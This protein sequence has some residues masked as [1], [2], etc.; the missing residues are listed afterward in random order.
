MAS[1]VLKLIES[2]GFD[3][4]SFVDIGPV[5]KTSHEHASEVLAGLFKVVLLV[6]GLIT[7]CSWFVIAELVP[8]GFAALTLW[9]LALHPIVAWGVVSVFLMPLY[10]AVVA[11]VFY[12]ANVDT[13]KAKEIFQQMVPGS[14]NLFWS[15]EVHDGELHF[16][17][18]FWGEFWAFATNPVIAF[19]LSFTS[20]WRRS[21]V[22]RGV[23]TPDLWL[24][25][26][27]IT[28]VVPQPV[29]KD[30]VLSVEAMIDHIEKLPGHHF[31]LWNDA[32]VER[33]PWAI[34]APVIATRLCVLSSWTTLGF[35]LTLPFMGVLTIALVVLV[36]AKKT[37][38]LLVHLVDLVFLWLG[39]SVVVFLL[40]GDAAVK[41][42]CLVLKASFFI[43]SLC[44]RLANPLQ[45][46][47]LFRLLRQSIPQVAVV[48][49]LSMFDW[50]SLQWGRNSSRR[51][52]F[53]T[54][55]RMAK[56][57]EAWIA[58]QR[59]VASMSLP[60]FTTNFP[61]TFSASNLKQTFEQLSVLGW[62]VNVVV[63]SY[64]KAEWA[65]WSDWQV[66]S[67]DF[68]QGIHRAQTYIDEQLRVFEQNNAFIYKRSESYASYANELAATSRYFKDV[69]YKFS[70]LQSDELWVLVGE[71]FRDSQLTSFSY[72]I[73]RW[74]KKYGLGAFAKVP[75][76][77]AERK[78]SRRKFI[79]E[80]G[81]NAFSELWAKTFYHAPGMVPVAP[82]SIKGEALP[83]KKWF[84]DKVRTVIGAPLTH[85]ITSTIFNYGPNHNFKYHE[86]PIKVGL[87]LTGAG[88]TTIWSRHAVK[89]IHYAGDCS[90]FDSTLSGKIIDLIKDVRKK[91][92]EKHR[93]Y[94]RICQLID[95]EYINIASQ[96]LAT[97]SNGRVFRKG[98]GLTTGHSS[99]SMDNSLGMVALYLMAW[100]EITGMSSQSFRHYVELSVYGDD[101]LIS[102]SKDAP[103]A[104][105][106]PNIQKVMAGWGITNRLEAEGDLS[107]LEFLSKFGRRPSSADRTELLAAGLNVPDWVI[108]HNRDK[109]IGKI[110][111][112]VLSKDLQY[113]ASRIKS[114][115]SLTAHHRD[116]YEQ[117]VVALKTKIEI[118][119][120]KQPTYKMAIPSYDS[121]LK[122]WYNSSAKV[123]KGFD[124]EDLSL[125]EDEDNQILVYGEI[126]LID[127]IFNVFGRIVD[128]LNPDVFNSSLTVFLQ[129]PLLPF[130]TWAIRFT[131]ESNFAHGDR[132]VWQLMQKSSY[133][134]IGQEAE[135]PHG[136]HPGTHTSR[137]IKHWLYM[138]F[139]NPTGGIVAAMKLAWVDHKLANIK[140]FLTG[141]IDLAIK[142]VDVPLWNMLLAAFIGSLPDFEL[143]DVRDFWIV[144]MFNS[145]TFGGLIDTLFGIGMNLLW[146]NI[147]PSFVN[148]INLVKQTA[149]GKRVLIVAPTGTGKSTTMVKMIAD[150]AYFANKVVV[151]VPR[152]SLAKGIPGYM[153]RQYNLDVG[154]VTS[155]VNDFDHKVVYVTPMEVLLHPWW[156]NDGGILWLLDEAHI[157]ESLSVF[158]RE[159]VLAKCRHVV[160]TTA[161][162]ITEDGLLVGRLRNAQIWS[163]DTYNDTQI[164]T[165]AGGA[166][167][168]VETLKK[169]VNKGGS[170]VVQRYHASFNVYVS[171]LQTYL[172]NANPFAKSL[173]FVNTRSES[174]IL[175]E[176]LR[177]NA[178]GGVALLYSG[179]TDIPSTASI[180]I[181]TSVSDVGVTIPA[182]DHVFTMNVGFEVRPSRLDY[183]AKPTYALLSKEVLMQRRGRTG[184][185]NNGKFIVFEVD[186]MPDAQPIEPFEHVVNLL[187]SGV[188]MATIVDLKPDW[189][190]SYVKNGMDFEHLQEFVVKW[191]AAHAAQFKYALEFSTDA[192]PSDKI[193]SHLQIEIDGYTADFE[194]PDTLTPMINGLNVGHRWSTLASFTANLAASL[195]F[196]GDRIYLADRDSMGEA[197][198][199]PT[200]LASLWER[201]FQSIRQAMA[202]DA[203][204]V[205]E[206]QAEQ[207]LES[208]VNAEKKLEKLKREKALVLIELARVK[209]RASIL[210]PVVSPKAVVDSLAVN[211]KLKDFTL[212]ALEHEEDRFKGLID[213][214]VIDE[215]KVSAFAALID[216]WAEM[217]EDKEAGSSDYE[218]SEEYESSSDGAESHFETAPAETVF[219]TAESPVHSDEEDLVKPPTPVPKSG[220]QE[221]VMTTDQ[222]HPDTIPFPDYEAISDVS[223]EDFFCPVNLNQT[224]D[225]PYPVDGTIEEKEI[226]VQTLGRLYER[227]HTSGEGLLCGARAISQAVKNA[228]DVDLVLDEVVADL[229][230]LS[231]SENFFNVQ[232]LIDY[233]AMYNTE[234]AVIIDGR[235]PIIWP[236]ERDADGEFK[237]RLLLHATGFHYENYIL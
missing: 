7:I 34:K 217:Q 141:H 66:A 194:L 89:D 236:G 95:R 1:T 131:A 38:N 90:D 165:R 226:F 156:A 36:A 196:A 74:N 65:D 39:F 155:G 223:V 220:H 31:N 27:A 70:D 21:R 138:A 43:I 232:A 80:I 108:Y 184:R 129:R 121:I 93:D 208:V 16:V 22:R 25:A 193:A 102:W 62:P 166:Y 200:K 6:V 219:E 178:R 214:D 44:W 177:G 105:T 12:T 92:F 127:A 152:H 233:A 170:S 147:P 91:G 109:L 139:R 172:D 29:L 149:T 75:G 207:A 146:S 134:W 167:T 77:F 185:T 107:A 195:E 183:V 9:V 181:S 18:S 41:V 222:P 17:P 189:I 209:H 212:W 63:S 120:R 199:A 234:L 230:R 100:K 137:L 190:V 8:G 117:L 227:Q 213:D 86:T 171:F 103:P 210:N 161:T 52:P 59:V 60:E 157:Q 174:E 24:T 225:D 67:I 140:Y 37:A 228:F 110:K 163:I 142:R 71:I 197:S 104:W 128:V 179:H 186:G 94:L 42:G 169:N 118:I 69:D 5:E 218:E 96:L 11:L 203:T 135:I 54:K 224:K 106:F 20:M 28:S 10:S 112:D 153:R 215:A 78:M 111:A 83:F 33:L 97:T 211:K 235:H 123:S 145:F 202:E 132:H 116:L 82:V 53:A 173:I 154:C 13:R 201:H 48:F 125:A 168:R 198:T 158:T 98:T 204:T 114:Y 4:L 182:V 150:T 46:K 32:E 160:L 40:P 187:A 175:A 115:L 180:F 76:R 205:L 45:W 188:S 206:I 35:L 57:N 64:D 191:E 148:V 231:K 237:P 2:G 229:Q 113:Q 88:M 61:D 19:S 136:Y 55:V 56:F 119:Q 73:S 72:I 51:S 162:P 122:E 23:T 130:L 99:T 85:Y 221:I 50:A 124:D 84:N 216:E 49:W 68:K 14:V 176:A 87:P 126:T 30:D 164:M 15:A 26:P 143:P 133:D 3:G 47:A 159:W 151:V 192:A 144:Q 58:A 79:S 101:H 81:R